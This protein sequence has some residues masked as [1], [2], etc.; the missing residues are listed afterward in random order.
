MPAE[1]QDY[2]RTYALVGSAAAGLPGTSAGQGLVLGGFIWLLIFWKLRQ[3]QSRKFDFY[4]QKIH[5]SQFFFPGTIAKQ[6][7]SIVQILI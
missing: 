7:F 1:T 2:S 4:Q 3:K 6:E 5:Y